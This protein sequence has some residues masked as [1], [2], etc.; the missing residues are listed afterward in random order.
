M[1]PGNLAAQ[2][3]GLL[4]LTW[5][6]ELHPGTNP[7]RSHWVS[8]GKET[9]EQR[10]RIYNSTKLLQP[11]SPGLYMHFPPMQI[12]CNTLRNQ[13]EPFCWFLWVWNQ[14][15]GIHSRSVAVCQ[16]MGRS[17]K[18]RTILQL[19]S[20][21]WAA[22]LSWLCLLVEMPK[23]LP[24]L[25]LPHISPPLLLNVFLQLNIPPSFIPVDSSFN[26]FRSLP[27]H[28]TYWIS[29]LK[30]ICSLFCYS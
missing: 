21:R 17:L 20:Y 7:A 5:L 28:F 9:K 16:K 6:W 2:F 26:P 29:R 8:L 15:P 30:H 13:W 1:A 22:I 23:Y 19:F 11:G 27:Y 10:G 14:A 3:L 4:L 18:F 24:V 12:Q 25:M